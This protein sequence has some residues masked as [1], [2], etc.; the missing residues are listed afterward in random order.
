M[1]NYASC[2]TSIGMALN[3][4]LMKGPIIQQ[5]LVSILLR[6]RSFMYVFA[7]DI[8]KMYRQILVHDEDLHRQ[9]IVWREISG[10]PLVTYELRSVSYGTKTTPFFA[11]ACLRHLTQRYAGKYP[12]GSEHIRKNFYVDDVLTEAP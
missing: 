12:V 11:T 8:I 3:D 1:Q 10:S 7:A 4:A 9:K 6:F 2:R 5:D